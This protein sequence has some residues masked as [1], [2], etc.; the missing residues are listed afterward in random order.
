MGFFYV[1]NYNEK[2]F[3]ENIELFAIYVCIFINITTSCNLMPSF[4]YNC[5]LLLITLIT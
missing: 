4:H 1:Q 3:F 2:G 5:V